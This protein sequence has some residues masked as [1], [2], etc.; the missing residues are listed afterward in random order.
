LLH[1]GS[2]KMRR[3]AGNRP[4]GAA[5]KEQWREGD[6]LEV[7]GEPDRWTPPVGERREGR[8]EVGRRGEMGRKGKQAGREKMGHGENLGRRKREGE[9]EVGRGVLVQK[10]GR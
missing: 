4:A 10:G 6:Q 5:V 8:R 9:K 2:L 1:D 7:E 3:K